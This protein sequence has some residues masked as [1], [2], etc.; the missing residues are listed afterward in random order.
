MAFRDE[1]AN[2]AAYNTLQRDIG[3]VGRVFRFAYDQD[4]VQS[5]PFDSLSLK[6]KGRASVKRLP[7]RRSQLEHLFSL[8]MPEQNRLCLSILASTG[9]RLD[10]VALLEW[11]DVRSESGVAYFDLQ[12]LG[13]IVKN[14]NAARQVPIP[15]AVRMPARGAGRLFTY[16]TDKDGKAQN[17]ASKALMRHIREVRDDP[18]DGRFTVHSLRHSYRDLLRDA[19]ISEE[20]GDFIVGHG[21]NGQ[22][23]QYG[24]GPSLRIKFESMERVDLSFLQ[25]SFARL[26]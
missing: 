14:D 5:N 19:G 16:A 2:R 3:V 12:R 22:G 8:K 1:L 21:G 26:D 13:K 24:Q 11:E 25:G 6:G 18:N 17:A 7:F 4:F 10:E 9:M 15:S 23:R 20:I